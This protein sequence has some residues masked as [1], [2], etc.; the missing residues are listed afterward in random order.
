ESA[1]RVIEAQ[2]I[3]KSFGS[4]RALDDVS[5]TVAAGEIVG[6]LGPNGS[7]KTTLLR[8]LTGFFP[9]DAGHAVVAGLRIDAAPLAVRELV[10]F[11]PE[12]SP[13][14]LDLT[15]EQLLGFAADVKVGLPT[16]RRERIEAVLG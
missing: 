13:L 11:L 6:L 7:G 9:P 1:N 14:Y 16:A 4:Q 5:F 10:G 15:V 8:I 3:A 2:G 12:Q